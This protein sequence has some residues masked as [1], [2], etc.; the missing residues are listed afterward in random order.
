MEKSSDLFEN[1]FLTL[2]IE[3]EDFMIS[4]F[5]NK[6][7]LG[8]PCLDGYKKSK[9]FHFYIHEIKD[10]FCALSKCIMYITFEKPE[11]SG[12]II[13]R[14]STEAY[15]W[16]GFEIKQTM[17]NGE[18]QIE[19]KFKFKKD[20][21]NFENFEVTFSLH[22]TECLIKIVNELIL[23]AMCVKY[24][25]C[26][27]L[28]ELI[29]NHVLTSFETKVDIAK[30]INQFKSYEKIGPLIDFIFYYRSMFQV[31][32]E[33]NELKQKLLHPQF[34]ID[35]IQSEIQETLDRA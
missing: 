33:T 7:V 6:L 9:S 27:I 35:E 11:N 17:S 28:E 3:S 15:L 14:G 21:Q 12:K 31:L 25:D 30:S 2:N 16:E 8:E 5:P 13:E 24:T 22:Q 34:F 19:R 32:T 4:S 29:E 26:K 20:N 10:L 18:Q 1:S 23:S